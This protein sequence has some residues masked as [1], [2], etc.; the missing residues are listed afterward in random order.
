IYVDAKEQNIERWYLERFKTFLD[1]A[2]Q[3]PSN[4]YHQFTSLPADETLKIA[5]DTWK[6][7]N[8]VN[9]RDYIEPTRSRAE[10]ILHKDKTHKIDKIYLKKY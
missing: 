7:V 3:N 4:Y 8:L 1:L 6:K 2:K 9:L 10:V 5:R